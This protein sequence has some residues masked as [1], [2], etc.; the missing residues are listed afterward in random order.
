MVGSIYY[1]K[2]GIANGECRFYID[3]EESK[4]TEPTYITE[5]KDLEGETVERVVDSDNYIYFTLKSGRR[6]VI[7]PGSFESCVELCKS[8]DITN[9]ELVQAGWMTEK[10]HQVIYK[11][12]QDRENAKRAANKEAKDRAKYEELKK[13]FGD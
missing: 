7:D 5:W 9:R 11:A 8:K 3:P 4:M 12:K 10:E 13:K 1:N 6:V 2:I